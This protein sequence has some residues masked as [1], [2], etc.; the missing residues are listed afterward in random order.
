MVHDALRGMEEKGISAEQTRMDN[1]KAAS[2]TAFLGM[3]VSCLKGV[4][5]D[6]WH[7]IC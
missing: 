5:T 4:V 7:P 3:C 2:G 6:L 1:L